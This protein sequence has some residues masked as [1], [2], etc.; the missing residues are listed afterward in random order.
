MKPLVPLLALLAAAAP[1]ANAAPESAAAALAERG[2]TPAR[3]DARMAWFRDARFGMFI[4]WGLYSQIGGEWKGKPASVNG[5]AEWLMFAVK[6]PVAE[7]AAFAKQ[8]NPV[9]YD[10][11]AWVRAAKAAGMKYIVITT[12]HHEGFA[13]F[14]SK[15]SAYNIADATPYGKDVIKPLAE[16]CRRHGIKLGFYYSQNLD[17]YHPGGGSSGWDP[18]Q[19]GSA[20]KYVDELVIPQL[21][22]ILS[23]YGKVDILWFDIV[24]AHINKSRADRIWKAVLEKQPGLIIN[25][26]LGGGYHGDIETPEQ[27]IPPAGFPGKDWESCM[28]MNKTWGFSK[29]DNH[30]K[31]TRTL[32]ENLADIASKGGNYLLNVGPN[33]LGEIPAPSLERLAEIGAW[34]KVNGEAIHATRSAGFS[35]LPEWGRVTKRDNPNGTTTLY[36]I[37]F[38]APKSGE[39]TFPGLANPAVSARI[40]GGPAVS[41]VSDGAS[42]RVP[43]PASCADMKDFVVAINVRGALV[44]DNVARPLASGEYRL[45][46]RQAETTKGLREEVLGTSGVDHAPEPHL[47][48]WTDASA[49]AS[50]KL[51]A[52]TAG[53]FTLSARVGAPN[54]SAGSVLEFVLGD[55]VLPL[56]IKPTGDWNRYA[57]VPVGTLRVPAGDSTLLIR[58]KTKN[59][60]AP[61]NLAE[62]RLEPK[63]K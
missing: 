40:L 22:E 1:L 36:A 54:P 45:T 34:M 6:P 26:R 38:D 24:N 48:C 7:Y 11:D 18:V 56:E 5:C 61:C 17:W 60:E 9:K 14:K 3:H 30:W 16:A 4:H 55:T 19:K 41:P 2:E 21:R 29:H 35:T 31:P 63:T 43:L 47:G 50:W 13:M 28:T 44:T 25:N 51:K 53:E 62:L 33:E 49:T 59:G 52:K 15:A 32:I 39:I 10:P 12:K 42:L 20:D 27:H 57:T 58:V 8:F 23:N 46:P 37:V